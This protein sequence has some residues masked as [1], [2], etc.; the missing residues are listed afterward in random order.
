MTPAEER[1]TAHIGGRELSLS[2]LSKVMY[3]ATGFTKGELIDYYARI[4]PV[5]LTYLAGRPV[6]SKRFPNGVESQGFIEKNVPRHAPDWIRTAVLS[7]K[8]KGRD[9]NEYA[10]ID[11]LP[12]LVFFAN[13]AAIEF[14]TPMWRIPAAEA[15]GDRGADRGPDVAVDGGA[16]DAADDADEEEIYNSRGVSPDLIVFDLDPGPPAAIQECCQ[17]AVVLRD[18]LA[19]DGIELFPKTSGSKGMQLYG[20]IA[21]KAWWGLEVNEF[22]HAAAEAVETEMPEQVVSRMTKALRTG[23]ILIDWSQNNPAKTTITPYSMRS[24]KEPSVSTPVT[25]QEVE[26]C[27]GGANGGRLGFG[28]AEVL[29][30]VSELGDLLAPVLGAGPKAKNTGKAGKSRK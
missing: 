5:M 16:D 25:W 18:R 13:L 17:I 14:H 15:D 3:P 2:N 29:E 6:T 4:G 19:K 10:L 24:V 20:C 12:G 26:A 1:L 28:P 30:R 23:K 22:A 8:A 9:T 27:A 11:D 7:R 21:E